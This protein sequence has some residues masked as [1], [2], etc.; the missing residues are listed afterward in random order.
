MTGKSLPN[1]GIK[2]ILIIEKFADARLLF[3]H[4]HSIILNLVTA[5]EL[6]ISD[7]AKA[8]KMNPGLV[9]YYLKELEQHGLVKQ[10]REEIKGGVVKK[11]YRSTA[12]RIVLDRPV[13]NLQKGITTY[14]TADDQEGILRAIE[15]LGYH[16][17]EDNKEDAMDLLAKYDRR[18]RS[19]MIELESTGLEN[20]E[21]NG[22]VTDSAFHLILGIKA[23]RDPEFARLY[24]EFEKLFLRYE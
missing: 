18:I 20:F 3:S 4:K 11:Y 23:I 8:L 1:T 6:S 13:F 12:K 9:H 24:S 16:L 14:P 19:L 2:D 21:T 15:Y 7:I 17:P 10:V 5:S 22:F